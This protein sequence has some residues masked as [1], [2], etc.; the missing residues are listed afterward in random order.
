MQAHRWCSS[1]SRPGA[2][3][4]TAAHQHAEH[5]RRAV[6]A[7]CKHPVAV[8]RDGQVLNGVPVAPP[9][10]HVG[11][12][13]R[14]PAL[15]AAVDAACEDQRLGRV[16]RQPRHAL[17]ERAWQA[18]VGRHRYQNRCPRATGETNL[19]VREC[20]VEGWQRLCTSHCNPGWPHAGAPLRAGRWPACWPPPLPSPTA[21]ACRPC[22]RSWPR[23][24]GGGRRPPPLCC[25]HPC[26]PG[27]RRARPGRPPHGRGP[28]I[29]PGGCSRGQKRGL[30]LTKK[31]AGQCRTAR[32]GR[33]SATC[34]AL[35]RKA[36]PR[37]K[38]RI[39]AL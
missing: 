21:P 39:S 27:P 28:A 38:V 26:G 19:G 37:E 23:V 1:P 34:T 16:L 25:C 3:A 5:S 13:A 35:G 31:D 4:A 32:P 29:R 10:A 9:G 18:G 33:G 36:A 7:A 22:L 17:Q 11:P 8:W 2:A 20:K 6:L 15:H 14:V 12:C 24:A 30:D